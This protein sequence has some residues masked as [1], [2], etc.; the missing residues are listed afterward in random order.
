MREDK[1]W[2]ITTEIFAL[3]NLF[4]VNVCIWTKFGFIHTWH[5]HRPKGNKI[6]KDSVYLENS[7]GIHFNVVI[8]VL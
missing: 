2:G 1:V 8:R 6:V 3:A 5:T 4:Q 7:A